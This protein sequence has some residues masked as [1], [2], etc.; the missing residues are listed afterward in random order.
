M[1][2]MKMIKLNFKATKD[3]TSRNAVKLVQTLTPMKSEIYL[4]LGDRKV[5][6]KSIL[7]LLSANVKKNDEIFVEV[8]NDSVA[9]EIFCLIKNFF[10][11][12]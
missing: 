9:T 7:G 10:K 8:F 1:E 2:E 11:E 3:L 6:M 4:N 5:N 12:E